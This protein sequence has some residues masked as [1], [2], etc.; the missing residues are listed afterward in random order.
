MARTKQTAR[1]SAGGKQ[2]RLQSGHRPNPAGTSKPHRFRPGTVALREI[3]KYQKSTDLLLRKLPFQRLVKELAGDFKNDLRFQASS[4]LALQEASEALLVGLFEDTNLCAIHA[5]RITIMRRDMLLALRLQPGL[6]LID[7]GLDMPA[8]RPARAPSHKKPSQKRK[9]PEEPVNHPS[10]SQGRRR[11]FSSYSSPSEEEKE[12]R[13]HSHKES[14]TEENWPEEVVEH[15]YSESESE[16]EPEPVIEVPQPKYTEHE[17]QAAAIQEEARLYRKQE[18][19][20]EDGKV[21]WHNF[22]SKFGPVTDPD[23]TVHEFKETKWNVGPNRDQELNILCIPL[24]NDPLDSDNAR[25]LKNFEN[26]AYLHDLL[27]PAIHHSAQNPKPLCG[28]GANIR[29]AIG[30]I[31]PEQANGAD[32]NDTLR[33]IAGL[34]DRKDPEHIFHDVPFPPLNNTEFD[35]DEKAQVTLHKAF[36]LSLFTASYAIVA[37]DMKEPAKVYGYVLVG[38][39]TEDANG[40]SDKLFHRYI[41]KSEFVATRGKPLKAKDLLYFTQVCAKSKFSNLPQLLMG[42][43]IHLPE[44]ESRS[45]FYLQT[46]RAYQED[47]QQYANFVA[48]GYGKLGFEFVENDLRKRAAPEAKQAQLEK[49]LANAKPPVETSQLWI[50]APE[51]T[52]QGK[53]KKIFTDVLAVQRSS[54]KFNSASSVGIRS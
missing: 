26:S 47:V 30:E 4:I 6:H 12:T 15:K 21:Y 41:N 20:I 42:R 24:I 3:R 27:F 18:K 1:P 35:G 5:K 16:A 14:K 19:A 34:Y 46:I 7:F 53:Q 32:W 45:I 13:P 52:G 40:D 10:A 36:C 25:R 37:V 50:A 2:P 49:A 8:P 11:S 9:S 44:Y 29:G 22:A 38:T 23:G 31:T 28:V 39:P 33:F 51:T 43:A 17:K 48:G 54:A